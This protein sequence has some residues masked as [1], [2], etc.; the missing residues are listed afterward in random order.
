MSQATPHHHHHRPC[1]VTAPLVGIALALACVTLPAS[2]A[3]AQC[4]EVT[5]RVDNDIPGSGYSE[6]RPENWQSRPTGSCS[7][8]YRYLSHEIGDGS[9]RGK[10]IW[11]PAI[12]RAGWYEIVTGFR[13]TENRTDDADYVVHDDQG[14]RDRR[15]IDQRGEGGVRGT[16]WALRGRVHRR[17]RLRC[18]LR[19]GGHALRRAL[20][21][22]ARLQQGAGVAHRV[23]RA[24]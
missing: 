5:I 24:E 1:P 14:N 4:P 2:H 15:S 21:R 19:R 7:G 3:R 17:R 10:A 16:G 9:R 18:L 12:Q 22:R 6:E 13:A 11:R 8:T 23:R 20:W